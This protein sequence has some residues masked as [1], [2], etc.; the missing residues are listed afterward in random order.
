MIDIHCHILPGIDDGAQN[1]EE[2]LEMCRIAVDDGITTT[3]ASPHQHNGVYH[4]SFESI[5]KGVQEVSAVLHTENIPLTLLPGADVHIEIDTG[6]Q[7]E[8]GEIMTINNNK[9]YF[10]LEFPSHTIPPNIDK[11]IFQLLL[12]NITPVLT[13]PERIIEVQE[14][15]SVIYHI[16]SQG[17]L[18]QITAMSITGGFG[19]MAKKCARTLLEHNLAHLIAS[20]AH[21]TEHRPPVLSEG[22]EAAARIVGKEQAMR[23]VTSIPEAVVQGVP[24]PFLEPPLE[25]TR[26][27]FWFF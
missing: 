8:R 9:R 26:K 1:I 23:M 14:N 20:D 17:V 24:A 2:T 12:K 7:I 22:V 16:V 11:I 19:R 3:V 5:V 13:H 10:L 27:R 15:P 18:S 6:E 21:S 4:N 25:V